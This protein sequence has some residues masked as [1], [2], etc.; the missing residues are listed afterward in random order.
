MQA[1]EEE[2]SDELPVFEELPPLFEE[3]SPSSLSLHPRVKTA[4]ETINNPTI[5]HLFIVLT[6][7]CS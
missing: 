3:E 5:I 7:F 4:P 6:L 2:H 1:H